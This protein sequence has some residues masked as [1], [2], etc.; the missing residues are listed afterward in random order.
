MKRN[1]FFVVVLVLSLLLVAPTVGATPPEYTGT[2]L[3]QL[4]VPWPYGMTWA[5]GINDRGQVVGHSFPV[6]FA[7]RG[8]LWER[9][10][11]VDI[12][13]PP[14]N[15]FDGAA[16]TAINNR[17]QIVGN[18]YIEGSDVP[19]TAF[20]FDRG[21]WT[22]IK[23]EGADNTEAVDIN[24]R[25]QVLGYEYGSSIEQRIFIWND[26]E[27]TY[28]DLPGYPVSINERGQV[29]VRSFIHTVSSFIW[30][31]GVTTEV[32]SPGWGENVTAADIN[33][34]GQVVG[35]IWPPGIGF[36]WG[37]GV[38]VALPGLGGGG[39]SPT[40]IN[41]R[42]QIAGSSNPIEGPGH[43]VLW[44]N[45]TIIDLGT[46]TGGCHP[47]DINASGQV[48]GGCITDFGPRAFLWER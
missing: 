1:G 25:G 12:G 33:D 36:I 44:D 9:G 40:A 4:D 48:V 38:M 8:W 22:V 41:N 20:M 23:G 29:L 14:S 7:T 10:E 13:L 21:D 37:D 15:T 27:F 5:V 16:P 46:E 18:L 24:S 3:G 26:G 19:N 43:A 30:D 31:H 17:G 39:E 42:G 2:D 28:L 11:M 35:V 34:R 45:G 47:Y 32:V 6:D